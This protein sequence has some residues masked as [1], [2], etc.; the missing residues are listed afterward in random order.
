[1]KHSSRH[2]A[3]VDVVVVADEVPNVPHS[4]L[5][6]VGNFAVAKLKAAARSERSG[7]DD[8]PEP[9]RGRSFRSITWLVRR[10]RSPFPVR[11]KLSSAQKAH[12]SSA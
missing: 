9:P 7:D 4:D 8:S 2:P 3:I 1:M 6:R 11:T 12:A 5:H 10:V